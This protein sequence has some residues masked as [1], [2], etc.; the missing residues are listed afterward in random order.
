MPKADVLNLNGAINHE[1]I[2]A[3]VRMILEGLGEN[4]EREGLRHTAERVARM[5]A[6]LLQGLH[7]D[8]REHLKVVFDEQH[9]EMVLVRD[10]P[11]SSMCEHHLLPFHGRVHAAY[12]PHG[13][14]VGL[15]KIARVIESFAR[16]LQVQERMTEL[17]YQN[18]FWAQYGGTSG[19][20]GFIRMLDELDTELPKHSPVRDNRAFYWLQRLRALNNIQ[21]IQA[22]P[23]AMTGGMD[24][25]PYGVKTRYETG[26]A[27]VDDE[28]VAVGVRVTSPFSA[29]GEVEERAGLRCRLAEMT[30]SAGRGSAV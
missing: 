11:F 22:Q 21:V 26:R 10:V 2:V 24:F 6:E 12:I 4:P 25:S 5:Y 1:K 23:P 18:R 29:R 19:L 14:V 30:G 13:K 27:A 8:P 7:E 15:S 3:G 17:A 20:E 28:D 9:D 16:R